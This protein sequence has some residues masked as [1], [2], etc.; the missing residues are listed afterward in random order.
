MIIWIN[1]AFGAGKTTLAE[2]L[3]R[4]LP[5]AMPFD[6]EYVGYTLIKWCRRRAAVTS[7]TSPCGASSWPSSP[8]GPAH[9]SRA[10]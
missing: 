6:P 1:G 8:S 3:Q 5:E 9:A 2:E 10:G 7:R 4:R